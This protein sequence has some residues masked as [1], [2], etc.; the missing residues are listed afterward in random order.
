MKYRI[1]FLFLS[2][3]AVDY[4]QVYIELNER[5]KSKQF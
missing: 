1:Y 5:K 3:R 4:L 2:F